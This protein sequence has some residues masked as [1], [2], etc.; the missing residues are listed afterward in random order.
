MKT[1]TMAMFAVL[2]SV[3]SNAQNAQVSPALAVSD[4][5]P[6]MAHV[7]QVQMEQRQSVHG[8]NGNVH[9]RTY[10]W[11]LMI[12]EINGRT[13]GLDAKPGF[14]REHWLHMGDY[15]C[16]QTKKGFEV[17]YYDENGK[18]RNEELVIAS[19]E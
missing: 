17:E 5:Y 12:A 10:N 7:K 14:H 11:H 15:P 6:L 8:S 19:E 9:G 16:R 1:L 13:Y 18:L 2:V 3:M 4:K